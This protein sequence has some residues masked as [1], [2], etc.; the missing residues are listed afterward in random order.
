V[1][2][3]Q[4]ALLLLAFIALMA[5]PGAGRQAVPDYGK[6][7]DAQE[8]GRY[9]DAESMLKSAIEQA[10]KLGDE[11]SLNRSL[12]ALAGLYEAERKYREALPLYLK[13][14]ALHEKMIV[15]RFFQVG[16]G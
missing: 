14:L 10:E 12:E 2:P 5:V 1:N 13:S 6:V 4:P 9:S 16:A 8:S 11:P 7:A 15:I 3:K